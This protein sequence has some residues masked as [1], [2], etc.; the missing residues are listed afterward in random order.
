MKTPSSAR[1]PLFKYRAYPIRGCY[2]RDHQAHG[3]PSVEE[4]PGMA[5]PI[6]GSASR[7]PGDSGEAGR[8]I[9]EENLNRGDHMATSI[10][11]IKRAP[12]LLTGKGL[13]I[14]G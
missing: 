1:I 9:G 11:V 4:F 14:P 7:G 12:F 5:T 6:F 8:G 10:A 2:Y 3:S 13:F